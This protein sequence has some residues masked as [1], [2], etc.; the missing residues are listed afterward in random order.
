MDEGY[1]NQRNNQGNSIAKEINNKFFMELGED[2]KRSSK[3][4][5]KEILK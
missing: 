1:D 3:E 4:M 5:F 2:W